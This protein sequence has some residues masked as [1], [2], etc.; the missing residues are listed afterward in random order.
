MSLSTLVSVRRRSAAAD[1]GM[2]ATPDTFRSCQNLLG[3]YLL[4]QVPTFVGQ[5]SSPSSL[6]V[7]SRGGGAFLGS[8][9]FPRNPI[10]PH[11][12]LSCNVSPIALFPSNYRPGN[13][14]A[15]LRYACDPWSLMARPEPPGRLHSST[16]SPYELTLPPASARTGLLRGLFGHRRGGSWGG[17]PYEP[18]Y[19]SLAAPGHPYEPLYAITAS[20]VATVAWRRAKVSSQPLVYSGQTRAPWAP[21]TCPRLS[22]P[23]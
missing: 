20:A 3:A 18:S 7:S 11:G 12:V 21:S 2:P 22:R 13:L 14:A 23:S 8:R 10:L 5:D 15:R 16:G 6:C 17:T 19:L 1:S 9:R 4:P